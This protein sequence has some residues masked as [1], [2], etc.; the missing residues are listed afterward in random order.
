MKTSIEL[1]LFIF[2]G[3]NAIHAQSLR[4][5]ATLPYAGLSTYSK[6]QPDPFSFTSNQAAL[7]MVKNTMVGVY[8][9]RRFLLAATSAYRFAAVFPTRQGNFG[10]QLDHAGFANFNENMLGLAYGRHLGSTIELGIQFNYYGYR[11]PLYGNAS[12]IYFEAGAIFHFTDKLN[13]GI[14]VYNPVGGK[15]GNSGDEKMASVYSAGLGYDAS[16]GL[17][18]GIEVIKEENRPVNVISGLQYHFAGR[19]FAKAGISSQSGSV[20]AGTGAGWNKLRV[21]I[22]ASYHPV[23]G[24]S[25]GVLFVAGL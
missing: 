16:P 13:G 5:P 20:F 24:F 22:T 3:F 19:F 17:F 9:E 23:L 10:L 1:L 6:E 14:H 11:V 21:D 8:G 25:P 15:L 2:F 4:Y 12:T 18:A 7:G